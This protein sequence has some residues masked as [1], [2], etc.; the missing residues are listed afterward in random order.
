MKRRQCI[1]LIRTGSRTKV[2]G[3][4]CLCL[5]LGT[6]LPADTDVTSREQFNRLM[7]GGLPNRLHYNE[8]RA[9]LELRADDKDCPASEHGFFELNINSQGQVTRVK[10]MSMSRSGNPKRIAINWVRNILMQIHFRPLKLGS[11]TT[12]VHTFASV[13]CQ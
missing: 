10:D 3:I 11:K 9:S 7:P 5:G 12:S 6:Q 8:D 2:I 1:D 13:V 4:I